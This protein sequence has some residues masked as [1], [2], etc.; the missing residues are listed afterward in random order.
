MGTKRR[1][2]KRLLSERRIKKCRN[3]RIQDEPKLNQESTAHFL[4]KLFALR[5]NEN[6]LCLL[7]FV[8]RKLSDNME[9][10]FNI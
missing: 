8:H 10:I 6:C 7:Q 4:N 3:Y 5:G 9:I 1:L 2:S